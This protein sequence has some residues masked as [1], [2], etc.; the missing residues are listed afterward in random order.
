MPKG[1][2]DV[3]G[4]NPQVSKLIDFIKGKK[5]DNQM[6]AMNAPTPDVLEQQALKDAAAGKF[7]RESQAMVSDPQKAL[8]GMEPLKDLARRRAEMD[9]QEQA[10]PQQPNEAQIERKLNSDELVDFLLKEQE[11]K[12]RQ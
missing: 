11:K 5:E 12:L 10:A 2:A 6:R 8:A 4:L 7:A 3:K 1:Y 9:M